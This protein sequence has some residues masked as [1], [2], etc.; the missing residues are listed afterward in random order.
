[1][2]PDIFSGLTVSSNAAWV[3]SLCN[4]VSSCNV[5]V[6]LTDNLMSASYAI[7]LPYAATGEHFQASI[8]ISLCDFCRPNVLPT[9]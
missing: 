8:D 5:P 9:V 4:F 7:S 6:T 3:V 1:M 2:Q